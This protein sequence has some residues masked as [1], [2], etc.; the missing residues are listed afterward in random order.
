MPPRGQMLVLGRVSVNLS[1][2]SL[3][4]LEALGEL[5]WMH[6]RSSGCGVWLASAL[7]VYMCFSR[8]PHTISSVRYT[9]QCACTVYSWPKASVQCLYDLVGWK[10]TLAQLNFTD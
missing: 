3:V 1:L 8:L 7:L 10:G 5:C 9:F 4:F 2:R 6:Y